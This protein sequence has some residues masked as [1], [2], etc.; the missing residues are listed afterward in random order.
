MAAAWHATWHASDSDSMDEET[1]ASRQQN[2]RYHEV[3]YQGYRIDETGSVNTHH[4][5][6]STFIHCKETATLRS[7]AEKIDTIYSDF[8][9]TT[10][11][12]ILGPRQLLSV[13]TPELLR[14][15]HTAGLTAP[16]WKG[17]GAQ[18]AAK[19]H[20]NNFQGFTL[21][22]DGNLQLRQMCSTI[23]NWRQSKLEIVVFR[24][25][26]KGP[27]LTADGRA[28]KWKDFEAKARQHCL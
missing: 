19:K 25:E 20:V 11:I 16:D 9:E 14:D 18:E 26:K 17:F 27:Q 6:G 28:M 3:F 21:E 10:A 8:G 1:D 15:L 22:N 4:E 12:G 2:A 23:V 24:E 13:D 5:M 7:I